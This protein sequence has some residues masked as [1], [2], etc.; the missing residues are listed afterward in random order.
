MH[1]FVAAKQ[2]ALTRLCQQHG[3]RQL[4]LFGSAANGN[5]RETDS[6][7][8]FLVEF[9]P[10]APHEHYEQYFGLIEDMEKLF[11]KPVEL[12]EASALRNPYFIQQ[13]DEDRQ[14]LYAA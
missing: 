11:G 4:H 2:E 3:V 9:I 5:F 1:T 6:D 8:D 10:C 14:L 7:L 12:V 13:V